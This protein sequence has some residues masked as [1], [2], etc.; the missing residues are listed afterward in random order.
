MK[1]NTKFLLA[2]AL[3]I[4][5]I[6]NQLYAQNADGCN[7][8]ITSN[9]SSKCLVTGEQEQALVAYFNNNFGGNIDGLVINCQ[10]S[11]V[12]YYANGT[13]T[14][15]CTW[16]VVGASHYNLINNGNG[17]RIV[18]DTSPYGY[19]SVLS[20]NHATCIY[21]C[22]IEKPVASAESAPTF[23]WENGRKVIE[24]CRGEDVVFTDTT[25]INDNMIITGYYWKSDYGESSKKN[26][27]IYNIQQ[28]MTVTHRVINECGCE[29]EETY[30]IIVR[31]GQKLDLSCYGTVC[32]GSTVTYKTS[33]TS[34]SPYIWIVK[35]GQLISPQNS[36]QITV[37][38]GH[39]QSGYGSIALDGGH[40]SGAC[41]T[42]MEVKIPIISDSVEISGPEVVCIKDTAFYELPLWGSTD[43]TWTISSPATGIFYRTN[44]QRMIFFPQSGLYTITVEYRCDFINCGG[45]SKTKYVEV[46]PSMKIISDDIKL[47]EG[48]TGSYAL[49]DYGVG[50]WNIVDE[51]KDT[52]YS[53]TSSII[54]YIFEVPGQYRINASNDIYCNTAIM[55]VTVNANPD[56]TT[57]IIG[58][59]TACP[60]STIELKVDTLSPTYYLQWESLCSTTPKKGSGNTF[61]VTYGDTVCGVNVYTVN[62]RTG[63]RSEP[64]LHNII[65]FQLSNLVL[66]DEMIVCPGVNI[67]LF[68]PYD[69]GVL[70]KW[71]ITPE[72]YA[73][74]QGVNNSND[75]H[76][77][78]NYING[79]TY[80]YGLLISLTRTYCTNRIS[81]N[82]VRV[83]VNDNPQPL[84]IFFGNNNPCAGS[85]VT[86]TSNGT[87]NDNSS[88]TWYINGEIL[89]G[90]TVNYSF[91]DGGDYEIKLRYNPSEFCQDTVSFETLHVNNLPIISVVYQ[92]DGEGN[93]ILVAE[94]FDRH[95]IYK[96]FLDGS[97]L[98]I[99]SDTCPYNG[100]GLY[101]CIVID[102]G[103]GCENKNC[104]SLEGANIENP[105][106]SLSL[107]KDQICNVVYP[108]ICENPCP[109]ERVHL[110]TNETNAIV[111]DQNGVITYPNVGHYS[112]SAN[113]LCGEE[114]FNGN[115]DVT[116]EFVPDFDLSYDCDSNKL[117]ITD[118]SQYLDSSSIGDRIF[119][120]RGNDLEGDFTMNGG[121]FITYFSLYLPV[122]D[123]MVYTITM[124]NE[125]CPIDK[126]ITLYRQLSVSI[127]T[128]TATNLCENT[129][130]LFYASV[131]GG[132]VSDY[133]WNFGDGSTNKGNNIY[134]TYKVSQDIVT[135][136]IIDKNGCTI[137]NTK[138]L[139]ILDYPFDNKRLAFQEGSGYQVCPGNARNIIYNVSGSGITFTWL[140]DSVVNH[141][142]NYDVYS[143]N[144]YRV[145]VV[146]NYGCKDESMINVGFLNKP[147]A[148]IIG[149]SNYCKYDIVE[150]NGDC[151][152][153]N[154]YAWKITKPNSSV[155][156]FN[157]PSITFSALVAGN[158]TSRLIV[159]NGTCSDTAYLNFVVNDAPDAPN[160]YIN[161]NACIDNPPVELASDYNVFWNTGVHNNYMRYY[162]DGF[163]TAYYIHPTS[164]CKSNLAMFLIDP[165]PF[166]D[167]LLTGCYTKCEDDFPFTLSADNFTVNGHNWQWIK[168][169]SI[170]LSGTTS[171]PV[172]PI[173][174]VGVY[175]LKTVYNRFGC[176]DT[177]AD[178]NI[179]SMPCPY[180]SPDDPIMS[181]I[182]ITKIKDDCSVKNCQLTHDIIL[183]ICNNDS[184]ALNFIN[185]ASP[186][187]NIISSTGLPITI[188]PN[189]CA[190]LEVSCYNS[191]NP[192][193]ES[194]EF[195]IYCTTYSASVLAVITLS[196]DCNNIIDCEKEIALTYF[197]YND[198]LSTV[199]QTAAFD[200][201]FSLPA[202]TMSVISMYC[203]PNTIYNFVYDPN[204][205][206]V[207][208]NAV[209][210][211]GELTQLEL[212]DSS[213]VCFYLILCTS[214]NQGKFCKAK[215]CIDVE[216]VLENI[217]EPYKSESMNND[218]NNAK[219][220]DKSVYLVPNPAKNNVTVKGIDKDNI[221][222]I[223]L[224]D[225]LGKNIKAVSNVN[226]LNIQD[227]SKGSYVVRVRSNDHNVYYL[228]LI[229]N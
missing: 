35:N 221:L 44:N 93:P 171:T 181:K 205:N 78:V 59:N 223:L 19:V 48:D 163:A 57:E 21:V 54:T 71:K 105:C 202:T 175:N 186:D 209:F 25:T 83:V 129:P 58:K 166:Y 133:L 43:Y 158:Y 52:V 15:P 96:W 162:S 144:D 55:D 131:S 184:I 165:A 51:N 132:S 11:E 74:V 189:E 5:S 91:A 37:Q 225:M 141:I 102:E 14:D 196:N 192:F 187:V 90:R 77:L 207:S 213:V 110:Y 84:S 92:L 222:E 82:E 27:T 138:N 12:E 153:G 137:T 179:E 80:P 148:E 34:C 87:S 195:Y 88:Y 130:Y 18:W 190:Y 104:F 115:I 69:D 134:H 63:C 95:Y 117:I 94:P 203:V 191:Q 23:Y 136:T 127:V 47:C 38:W 30:D 10:G 123:S 65:P 8:F 36:N 178:L 106:L 122:V 211:Y 45:T 168:N 1:T 75:I 17:V 214:D 172:L 98:G 13:C 228:K 33:N 177:S 56:T 16:T 135:L 224:L 61:S 108:Y 118:K 159:S 97:D 68:T 170:I 193:V 31:E 124:N 28:D 142:N 157:T 49:S 149:K 121:E 169:N 9:F 146:N 194:A 76:V 4:L 220:S 176:S 86:F 119:H 201:K 42:L 210:N 20:G 182:T 64:Y 154:T 6:S 197:H 174:S 206:T 229:K 173:P 89:V 114:C 185:I 188:N 125:N 198:I 109:E 199:N 143:T 160:I 107:C 180:I 41:N 128:P 62:K 3:A 212:S 152:S 204:N 226:T 140:P 183:E 101:C 227:I 70:Y 217:R 219:N 99:E 103:T 200:F 126:K 167:A 112:I 164:G 29:D 81:T 151:G 22:L 50:N 208:G 147:T 73:S 150:L 7:I 111:D 116:I 100:N 2:I 161:G 46:K 216:S 120:I 113:L 215:Y 24:A 156:T 79:A 155:Q 39:P 53:S 145:K 40:C 26:Y 32:G 139:T 60:G 67:P 66:P 85:D 72:S 218:T